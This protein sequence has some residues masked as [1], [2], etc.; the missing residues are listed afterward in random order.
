MPMAGGKKT[1]D[2]VRLFWQSVLVSSLN[3]IS[4]KQKLVILKI[5]CVQLLQCTH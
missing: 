3:V 2:K 5:G 4:D 1:P